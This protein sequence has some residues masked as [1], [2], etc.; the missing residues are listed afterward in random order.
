MLCYDIMGNFSFLKPV[1]NGFIRK[2][3]NYGF[4]KYHQWSTDHDFNP[5]GKHNIWLEYSQM[6]CD[7]SEHYGKAHCHVKDGRLFITLIAENKD[8]YVEICNGDGVFLDEERIVVRHWY[9]DMEMYCYFVI[10]A[11]DD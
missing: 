3:T 11:Y 8:D 6:E 1:I 7:T 5:I 10:E 4:I 2:N 9:E